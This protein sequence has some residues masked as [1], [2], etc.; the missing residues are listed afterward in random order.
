MYPIL[1]R[2][3]LVAA[4]AVLLSLAGRA[5][6]QPDPKDKDKEEPAGAGVKTEMKKVL[7]KAEE[8]YRIFFKKPVE[9]PEFWAAIKFEIQ[10]GKFDVAALHLDQM[11]KRI[12]KLREKLEEDK[13]SPQGAYADLL[14]IEEVEGLSSFLRLAQV[15][16]W[17]NNPTLQKEAQKNVESLIDRVTHALNEYLSDPVRI[18]KFIKNLEAATPEE[19]SFAF[20]QLYRSRGRAS[21]YLLKELRRTAGTLAQQRLLDLMVKLDPDIV[22]P[23]LEALNARDAKDAA[24][25]DLRLAL[26]ELIRRRGDKHAIPYLWSLSSAAKYPPLVRSR[27]KETLAYLLETDVERLP[28]AKVALTQL[29]ED[30][31]QHRVKFRDPRRVLVWRWQEDYTIKPKPDEFSASDYEEIY[32]QRYARQALELDP[33][34]RPAQL[35]LLNLTLERAY[36]G[37]LDQFTS[38]KTLPAIDQ[39]LVTINSELLLQMLERAM[40]EHHL[41]LILPALKALG[42]R[43]EVRAARPPQNGNAGALVR[44]L[45]YPDRRVQYA[46]VAAL[47]RLPGE[48]VPV[49][50]NRVVDILRRFLT[51]TATPKALVISTPAAKAG[52]MRKLVK[53]VGFEPVLVP[54]AKDA[55]A[56]LRRSADIDLILLDA[57]VPENEL[58]YALA[59]LRNDQDAGLLPLLLITPSKGELRL[60]SRDLARYRN[61]SL[62]PEAFLTDAT[63]L[64]SRL[65]EA[66][67][68]AAVPDSV[69]RADVRQAWLKEN[70]RKS[71]GQQLSAGERK[72]FADES[73]DAL[74]RMASG[75]TKGYDVRAAIPEVVDLLRNDDTALPAIAILATLP[76]AE[77]QQRLAAL[78]LDPARG[79]LQVTAATALNRH[80]QKNGLALNANQIRLLR[81]R[82]GAP[83]VSPTLRAQL[84]VF[85]GGLRGS[86]AQTGARLY[87]FNPDPPAGKQ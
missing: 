8:E 7:A 87:R 12:D 34:Y 1:F 51:T 18:T 75:L 48:P 46:A 24:D 31:Y 45:Y 74:W 72:Q 9:V 25:A 17:S 71:K 11:L 47:L 81:D 32:G 28:P 53:A 52:E 82:Y 84:A 57:A 21:P 29:A 66:I 65:E 80:V 39:L 26:L 62:L 43:G 20:A 15:R 64:K 33:N 49:A 42:D 59:Q 19:R 63:E 27:A 30:L 67:K 3:A 16:R 10:V 37:K 77:P 56:Q 35:V 22:P 68:F 44:A 70:V 85:V 4:A 5:A 38:G 73:L 50:G 23:L 78:V 61:V 55:L 40:S 58:P 79:K 83:G 14:A 86:A 13:K 60:N 54:T 6:A 36:E 76:G 2:C 41:A 69:A